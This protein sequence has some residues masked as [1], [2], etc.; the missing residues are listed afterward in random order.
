MKTHL[1]KAFVG[2]WLL[3]ASLISKM[4]YAGTVITVAVG[5]DINC[6]YDTITAAVFGEPAVDILILNV[7]KNIQLPGFQLLD[8]RDVLIRGG[9]D[10]CSDTTISGRSVLDGSGFSGPVLLGSHGGATRYGVVLENIEITG[11]NT[12]SSGGAISLTGEWFLSLNNVYLH[13]NFANQYGGA[14][15]LGVASGRAPEGN[16][17]AIY[18][19]GDSIIASNTA[20]DGGGIACEADALVQITRSQI[21]NNTASGDGGGIYLGENCAFDM[22]D[23]VPFQGVLLN[24]AG[25]FGGGIYAAE[26]ASIGL[27]GNLFSAETAFVESNQAENGGGIA[28]RTGAVLEA[29]DSAITNNTATSTGGGIRSDGGHITI[30]RDKVGQECHTEVR[31]SR[32]SGNS[33]QGTDASFAG[34]GAILAFGGTIDIRGTYIENNSAAHGSAM[35][36]RF[37]GLDGLAADVTMVGNVFSGNEN[38][39]QLILLDDSDADIGFNT[40]IDNADLTEVIELKYPTTAADGH[41]TRIFGNIFDEQGDTVESAVLTGMGT[42]PVGDCNRNEFNSTGDL[43]GQP[44]SDT[45]SVQYLDRPGGDFR[46]DPASAYI[47]YCDGSFLGAGSNTSASGFAR[48]NDLPDVLNVFGSYDLGGIEYHLPDLIFTDY[49]GD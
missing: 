11:G 14:V 19:Q 8:T 25:G 2:F 6:D 30:E 10:T 13:D 15:F 44:R 12:S 22:W 33:A 36:I 47:D 3:A 20:D 28:L 49:F 41:Q 24:E 48:P 16:S 21:A 26:N 38:A 18:V 9:Y 31:C 34:G 40:F 23:T 29:T 4:A 35:R 43:V 37:I 1:S 5:D 42:L 17:S 46:L 27:F 7:A 45:A 32:L 39:S